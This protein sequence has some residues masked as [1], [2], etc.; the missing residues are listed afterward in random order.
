M[1]VT[2]SVENDGKKH[3]VKL[4]GEIDVHT[5][6]QVQSAVLALTETPHHHVFID[7]EKVTYLDSTG[8]GIFVA[9]Y[10]SAE[11]NK[12]KLS[13]INAQERVFRLFKITGLD[14]IIDVQG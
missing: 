13:I 3:I 5:I 1:N 6:G 14:T 4:S 10:K 7:L 2:I 12:S 9:A 8:L 11:K